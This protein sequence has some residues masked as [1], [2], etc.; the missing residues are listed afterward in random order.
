MNLTIKKQIKM[1]LLNLDSEDFQIAID[2][3]DVHLKEVGGAF[4]SSCDLSERGRDD[5]K[6]ECA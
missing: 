6:F 2:L 4:N 5:Y 3:M 1:K